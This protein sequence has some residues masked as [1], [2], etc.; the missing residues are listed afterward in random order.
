M[1][2]FKRNTIQQTSVISDKAAMWIANRILKMQTKFA[3]ILY[4]KSF[5]WK[6]R[7]QWIF[8]FTVC[9]VFGGLSVFIVIRSFN[10]KSDLKKP[11]AIQIPKM[12]PVDQQH[13]VTITDK[14]IRQVHVFK[15]T[16]DS[17][18]RSDDGKTKVKNLL[19]RRPGLMDSLE[20]VEQSYYSQ[21]K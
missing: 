20:L 6:T 14:E 13:S 21:K 2:L 5:S 10:N 1:R 16:L 8:L 7:Q 18:S 12:M 17:L 9:V 3:D 4:Q 11:S 15:H 19:G